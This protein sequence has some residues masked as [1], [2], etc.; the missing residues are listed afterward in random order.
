MSPNQE[1]PVLQ[2][3]PPAPQ[4]D[5]TA[6]LVLDEATEEIRLS[7]VEPEPLPVGPERTLPTLPAPRPQVDKQTEGAAI[8]EL[9]RFHV[10]GSE[11]QEA[12]LSGDVLP[13][14]MFPLRAPCKV[15][16]KYPLDL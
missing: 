11:A 5:D 9:R 8:R 3:A 1:P 13:A 7:G 14:L 4:D 6:E 16:T 2:P 10:V 15:R 12:A